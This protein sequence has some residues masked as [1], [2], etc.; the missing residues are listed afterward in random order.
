MSVRTLN[1]LLLHATRKISNPKAFQRK[2]NQVYEAVPA[3]DFERLCF[4][5]A[6]G[7]SGLGVGRGDRVALLS[8]N[9]LEWAVADYGIL[10]LGGIN[11]PI[12]PTLLPEQI[13]YILNDAG[14]RAV[15]VADEAQ[16]AKVLEIRGQVRSLEA[17]IQIDGA[18]ASGVLSLEEL[19]AQGATRYAAGA[20]EIERVALSV[21]PGDPC[22]FIYT[23]G[24]TGDPKGVVLSHWNIVSNVLAALEIFDISSRDTALSFLPLSHIFERMAG[25][26]TM[27]FAGASIA[28]AESIDTVP[29]NLQEVHPTV[30]VSVPRL[31]E[32]MY[33]RILDTALAGG[34]V[35]KNIFFWAKK[36]GERW[37]DLRLAHRPV[38]GGLARSYGIAQRLVF[39]KLKQR[40]GGEMRFF[41]SGGAP[42][43]PEIAKFFYAAGLTILEGYGLTETSPV[44]TANT[45]SA[46]KLGTVGRTLPGIEVRIAEDGEIL[47][48]GPHVMQGYYRNDAATRAAIDADGWFATG[49]IG[50]LDDEGF[51][52]IT[53]RKKDL[54]VTA[55]GKNVAPQPIEN[56]LKQDKFI[57]ECVLIGD[58]RPF[59]AALIVPNFETLQKYA[60]RKAIIYTSMKGLINEPRVQDLFSRRVQRYNESLAR[61]EQVRQFRLLD[62]EL[63]L[64]AGELTPSLKVRRRRVLEKY[65]DL[66]AT[67]YPEER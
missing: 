45:F 9:R 8:P 31:Y 13:A 10:L 17:I 63:T 22:S 51:L 11:V 44:I 28:Y 7:L 33:A 24:T 29:Q 25:Y 47:T 43:A 26:Y 61:F 20:A 55:G 12:Y 57:S 27:L 1:E 6:L 66:I 18:R 50:E 53:D 37:A 41:I 3:A 52:R 32:K 60:K 5:T 19:R 21:A 49:D 65:A 59:I 36:T 48:R 4:E 64:E 15:V 67:I 42:L 14:A 54:L 30:M 35:K 46:I 34:F 38:P 58:R 62:Q 40:T 16:A 39:G 2:L 56:M 23:S